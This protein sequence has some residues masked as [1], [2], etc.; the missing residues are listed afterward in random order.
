MT[1]HSAERLSPSRVKRI[2]RPLRAKCIS[3]ATFSSPLSQPRPAVSTTYLSSSRNYARRT[4]AENE[5][6]PLVVLQPPENLGS[7]IHFDR[8]SVESLQ[9]SKK[10]YEVRDAF[11]NIVQ[12]AFRQTSTRGPSNVTPIRSLAAICA[13]VIGEHIEDEIEAQQDEYPNVDVCD[14]VAGEVMEKVYDC[15]PAHHRSYAV[16]SHALSLILETCQ[17]RPT[18]LTALLDVC[19]FFDLYQECGILL[20]ALFTA[21]L[22]PTSSSSPTCPLSHS[23]H[24]NYLT[25][26]LPS[27]AR[28][29]DSSTFTQIFVDVLVQPI[30]G[31]IEA[32]TSKAVTR[33]ARELRGD[34]F[35][36]FI[37]LC[38]GLAQTINN[39]EALRSKK[40][41][42]M[43]S[44][45]DEVVYE[46][47]LRAR[48]AKWIKSILERFYFRLHG[49]DTLETW[50]AEFAEEYQALARFLL[51]GAEYD[52]YL[53]RG[54]PLDAD[55]CLADA[56]ICVTTYCLASPL[57]AV[58]TTA[59]AD[60]LQSILRT[61]ST[62]T[63]SYDILVALIL[64]PPPV[65]PL[66]FT[67]GSTE[68]P[69]PP[70]SS[71]APQYGC[72][73]SLREI[74][75]SLRSRTLHLLEAAL[76][77]NALRHVESH[78][79]APR[80]L[81]GVD[82]RL[83]LADLDSLRTELVEQVEKAEALH[84]GA[85]GQV[86]AHHRRRA[87][88]VPQPLDGQ[89]GQPEWEWEDMV[90][91]WVRSSP[92]VAAAS[93]G[94]PK[95]RKLRHDADGQK[96]QSDR[97]I[98]PS[99]PRTHLRHSEGMARSSSSPQ[100]GL[101]TAT[102]RRKS[103]SASTSKSTSRTTSPV[104]VPSER[105]VLPH[106]SP[107]GHDAGDKNIDDT[108]A[109][110]STR[111]RKAVSASNSTSMSRSTFPSPAQ[112]KE[113]GLPL[114]WSPPGHSAGDED[115]SAPS[116]LIHKRKAL[117]APTPKSLLRYP[118]LRRTMSDREPLCR[119]TVAEHNTDDENVDPL[120]L[121]LPTPKPR[122]PRLS[123]FTT[124]LADAQRNCIVL[125]P[126]RK[127]GAAKQ[128]HHKGC[129]KSSR[130]SIFAAETPMRP[131]PRRDSVYDTT[132]GANYLSSDDAL[133]LFAYPD[134]SPPAVHHAC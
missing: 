96:S 131:V 112:S 14:Y 123:N 8:A 103:A 13:S 15:V 32:W 57:L 35:G 47:S 78:C 124:I 63:E 30:A 75:E 106:W 120:I 83:S 52:L 7:R 50:P 81:S 77:S 60:R 28:V 84:F 116:S 127:I 122:M 134:S 38:S 132:F 100:A 115:I 43:K 91:C 74:A 104:P 48:L 3:L 36:A 62:R 68:S 46:Y 70:L 82:D 66:T 125:H 41:A 33:L 76:W 119:A 42:R 17:H 53:L 105:R 24:S 133:N 129:S 85:G 121:L 18:L 51:V 67:T 27:V 108:K 94:P 65:C 45:H 59:E 101:G 39:I 79:A 97:R 92:K 73:E 44:K 19:L 6:P 5:P 10:I 26:L 22:Q 58:L 49:L 55:I 89:A 40:R 86:G 87:H 102:R 126:H 61:T 56:L 80:S 71:A 31:R 90:G 117:P 4:N 118:S 109:S 34:D 130:P 110:I 93:Q 23:A 16:V 111:K 12:L 54:L 11:R 114:H 37:T 9:L 128:D 95:R 98:T 99:Q 25:A 107:S 69:P 29:I 113:R 1:A 20:Q 64:S 21:A 88:I 72:M 2:F